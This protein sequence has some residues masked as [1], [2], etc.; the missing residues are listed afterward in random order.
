VPTGTSQAVRTG[1]TPAVRTGTIPAVHTGTT[2][3]IDPGEPRSRRWYMVIASVATVAVL[4]TCGLFTYLLMQDELAGRSGAQADDSAPAEPAPRDISSREVDPEPLT[5]DEVFPTS[6]IIVNPEEPPYEVLGTQHL[7]DCAAAGADAL[8][9]LLGELDCT[10]VVRATLRSPTGD[11]L[12]TTGVLNLAT[13]EEA[14]RAYDEIG[15]LIDAGTGRFLGMVAGEGTE[16]IVLSQTHSGW[17]YRGHY[18]IYAV[19]ARSDGTEFS[20]ADNRG[21]DLIIW[22]M[23]EVHLRSGVLE[24]RATESWPDADDQPAEAGVDNGDPADEDGGTN[25]G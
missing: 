23:V 24:D 11:Y 12:I 21:V 1:T 3:V 5:E 25:G 20:E 17:D 4:A 18:L 9:D 19:I 8:A 15:E 13:E 7:T 10:Q 14:D 6:E 2:P 22:D 16:P